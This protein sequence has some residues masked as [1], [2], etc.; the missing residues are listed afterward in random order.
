MYVYNIR[1]IDKFMPERIVPLP[2]SLL[3]KN[4]R[5]KQTNNKEEKR[6]YEIECPRRI[7]ISP[8]NN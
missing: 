3:L 1:G 7:A 4:V 8:C 2:L 5:G 6:R